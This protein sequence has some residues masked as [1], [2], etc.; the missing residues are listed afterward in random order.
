MVIK[1][2]IK[3]AMISLLIFSILIIV[4]CK[5]QITGKVTVNLNKDTIKNGETTTI[6]VDGTN[7]GDIATD[8]IL[9]VI[10][11]DP[12][13][14]VVS[15]PGNLE[16]TLQP[17]ENTGKKIINVQGFTDYSSTKYGIISQLVRKDNGE[18]LDEKV[19]WIT[20]EK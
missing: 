15:Y 14:L 11:E 18:V 3:I 4:G 20:V 5:S 16:F 1:N 8:V 10:P 12:N 17:K 2:K 9:K 13:K 6:E 7:T 19:K